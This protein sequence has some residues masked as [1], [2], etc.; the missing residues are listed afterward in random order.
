MLTERVPELL[1]SEDLLTHLL[2]ENDFLSVGAFLDLYYS[3]L[4]F[5][6]DSGQSPTS[7]VVGDSWLLTRRPYWLLTLRFNNAV[8]RLCV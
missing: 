3:E 5:A 6:K 4:S 8:V 7:R 1:P 2:Q